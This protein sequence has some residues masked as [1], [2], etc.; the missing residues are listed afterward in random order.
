MQQAFVCKHTVCKVTPGTVWCHHL[1][2]VP[3]CKPSF[4]QLFIIWG[5]IICFHI[6]WSYCSKYFKVFSVYWDVTYILSLSCHKVMFDSFANPWTVA[7][8]LPVHEIS[9]ARI[10]ERVAMPF[11]SPGIFPPQGSNLRLL[12]WL[13]V[14]DCRATRKALCEQFYPPLFCNIN[15]GSMWFFQVNQKIFEMYGTLFQHFSCLLSGIQIMD[16]L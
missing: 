2:F 8:R 16:N 13:E 11:A 9:R 3:R 7:L 15:T 12:H 14:L 1:W 5:G 6:L 4:F 10:Q